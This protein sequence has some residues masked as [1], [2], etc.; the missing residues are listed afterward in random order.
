MP[1]S[2]T[3][4]AIQ[5]M[6]ARRFSDALRLLLRAGEEDPS[7]WSTWYMAGQC[8]RFS[9]DLAGAVTHLTRAVSLNPT[10]PGVFLALGIA[11]QLTQRYQQ[12]IEALQAGVRLDPDYELAYNSLGVTYRKMGQLAA[13]ADSY[14]NGLKALSRQIVKTLTNSPDNPI[15][16]PMLTTAGQLWVEYCMYGAMYLCSSAPQVARLAWPTGSQAIEE[17]RVHHHKGLYW[18]DSTD[19]KG[20]MTR[21]FLPNY[22]NAFQRA[23]RRDGTYAN[24][25]GNRGTVLDL[26]GKA[27]EGE[28]HVREAEE[29]LPLA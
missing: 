23:L 25:L 8:C 7:S 27:E 29:F 21:L 26:L 28:R 13:A 2:S 19:A 16:P 5:L 18:S 15:A 12:A 4:Q 11:L 9:N 10:D 17:E 1:P 6:Q 14:E 20:A 3:D 22:F 24:L